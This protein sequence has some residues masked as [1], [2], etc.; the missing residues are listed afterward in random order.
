MTLKIQ[1]HK[2]S[3]KSI[4]VLEKKDNS[5]DEKFSKKT[6]ILKKNEILEMKSSRNQIFKAQ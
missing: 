6:L 2:L 1:T 3:Q 5:M 4:E